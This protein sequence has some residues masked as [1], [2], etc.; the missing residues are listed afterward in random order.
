MLQ[1]HVLGSAG[2]ASAAELLARAEMLEENVTWLSDDRYR[3]ASKKAMLYEN[4]RGRTGGE[5]AS[6]SS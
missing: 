2:S 5:D 4:G 3:S 1:R 6:E